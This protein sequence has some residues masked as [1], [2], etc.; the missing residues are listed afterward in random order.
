ML[1]PYEEFGYSVAVWETWMAMVFQT[2]PLAPGNFLSAVYVLFMNY[3][4]SVKDYNMIRGYY[5]G[6]IPASMANGTYD[7]SSYIPSGPD[8][9]YQCRLGSTVANIGDWDEDGVTDMAVTSL[10]SSDGGSYIYLMYM[11]RTAP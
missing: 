5:K 1:Y 2:W 11:P 10:H 9:V 8:L 3:D 6:T 7:N 4:G